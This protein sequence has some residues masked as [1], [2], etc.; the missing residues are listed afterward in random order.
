MTYTHIAALRGFEVWANEAVYSSRV[1]Y[2]NGNSSSFEEQPEYI[3][4]M[5]IDYVVERTKTRISLSGNHVDTVKWEET[6]G[7]KMSY[8]PE[9]LVNLTVRQPVADG[10]EAFVEVSNLLDE[11]RI[12]TGKNPD[13][14]VRRE[15]IRNGRTVLMGMSYV[16]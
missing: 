4:N 8:A 13:N 9:W 16:F 3:A 6:D 11:E 15:F 1:R 5:G 7:T 12:E 14:E 10:L 2:D